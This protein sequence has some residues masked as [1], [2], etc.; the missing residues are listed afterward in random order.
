M[1]KPWPRHHPRKVRCKESV[2]NLLCQYISESSPI[3]I[4]ED[5]KETSEVRSC[6]RCC[7]GSSEIELIKWFYTFESTLSQGRFDDLW[8]KCLFHVIIDYDW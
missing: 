1:Q 3:D 8:V 6:V 4:D 2:A 7:Y 5:Q